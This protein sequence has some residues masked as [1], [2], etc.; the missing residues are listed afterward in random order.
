MSLWAARA[1]VLLSI[2]AMVGI[3][4]PHGQRSRGIPVARSHKGAMEIV[5]LTVAWLAFLFPLVWLLTP[6]LAFADYPAHPIA[7]FAGIPCLI[8]GLW[9]LHRSHAHLGGNW[10]ITLEVREKHRLVTH[11]IYRRIRHPM[12]LALLVYSLGLALVLPN[13]LAG[14]AYLVAMGLLFGFRVGP[15]ERMMHEEFGKDYDAYMAATKR[16]LPGVW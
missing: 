14:P 8:L 7:L 13:W 3:R 11:G 5:L 6:L 16:L 10:S 1:I 2:V 12:Y 9:L 15:E 4:A